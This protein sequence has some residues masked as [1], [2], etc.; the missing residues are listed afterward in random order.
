MDNKEETKET[1][2]NMDELQVDESAENPFKTKEENLDSDVLEETSD[3]KLKEEYDKLN[4]QYIRLAADFDNYRKR[5]AQERENLLKFGME[6][7][8]KKMINVQKLTQI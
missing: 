1:V 8:L 7:A 3:G 4:S 5:Q 2:E 6:E